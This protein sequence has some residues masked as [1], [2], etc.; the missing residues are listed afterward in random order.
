MYAFQKEFTLYACLNVKEL[1]RKYF[2]NHGAL[3]FYMAGDKAPNVMW[4]VNNL[5]VSS[6]LH[7]KYIFIICGTNNIDHNSPQSIASTIISAGSEFQK[8][9][10]FQVIV[11]TL[12]PS[13]HKHSRRRGI[14]NT[15]NKLLKCQCLD[16]GFK[17][18][19]FK[20]NW[21]NNVILLTWNSF[22]MITFTSYGK[23]M[24]YWQK[25]LWTFLSFEIHGGL[26]K[27]FM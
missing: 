25:K 4:R 7:L 16:N 10:K 17:F 26:Y 19:E 22:T 27:T 15:V 13:D 21:L 18:L 14:I 24:N 1:W 20:S 11:I 5:H 2:S 12:L 23:T 9:L 8:S 6:N 3:D